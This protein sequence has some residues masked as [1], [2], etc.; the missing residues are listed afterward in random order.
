MGLKEL[1]LS[2]TSIKKNVGVHLYL[3]GRGQIFLHIFLKHELIFA[4]YAK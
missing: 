3:S 2:G 4:S 1:S